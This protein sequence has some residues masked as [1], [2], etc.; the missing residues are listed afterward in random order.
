MFRYTLFFLVFI[1]FGLH[2]Q[3]P[4]KKK[5]LGR[6]HGEIGAY[7]IN[8]GAQF[9]DVAQTDILVTLRKSDLDF[10]IGKNQMT[11]PY[12]WKKKDKQLIIIEFTRSTDETL[13]TL[14]LTKNRKEIT[15]EGIFPQPKA[16]LKKIKK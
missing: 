4:L 15:R 9:I 11:L 12:T 8:T 10:T 7:K 5:F 2:A 13:E 1:S 3:K 16:I 6:Y 14:I